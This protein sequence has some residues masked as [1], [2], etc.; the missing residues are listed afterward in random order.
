[1]ATSMVVLKFHPPDGAEKGLEIAQS[2]QQQMLLQLLDAAIV[3]WP[4]G[5]KRPTTRHADDMTWA[6]R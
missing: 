1:M 3:S 5:K 4:T 2:L 6:G